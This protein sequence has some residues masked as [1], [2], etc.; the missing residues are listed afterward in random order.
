MAARNDC[1]ADAAEE[2]WTR[3]ETALVGDEDPSRKDT[4]LAL[5][6]VKAVALVAIAHQLERIGDKLESIEEMV[7]GLAD[8][9]FTTRLKE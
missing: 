5:S 3:L 4:R 7:C 1:T 2:L 6:S 9:P 8:L